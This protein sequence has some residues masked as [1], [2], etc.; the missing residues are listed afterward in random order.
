M[1]KFSFRSTWRKSKFIVGCAIVGVYFAPN[2][3]FCSPTLKVDK[4]GINSTVPPRNLQFPNNSNTIND[5]N[6]KKR[7]NDPVIDYINTAVPY[8]EKI[9][10]GG[11]MGMCTGIA[12][13]RIGKGIAVVIGVGFLAL[14]GLSY[15]GY[16]TIDYNKAR[17]DVIKMVDVDGDGK[18]TSNDFVVFWNEF[19][20]IMTHQ[21]PGYAGFA[22]G[23]FVGFCL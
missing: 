20:R 1:L 4:E 11:F 23:V 15:Y 18:L 22:S 16:V 2:T 14:Q 12:L 19:K 3:V 17:D 9:G 7:E 5:G 10:F 21:L 6:D 13:K 8:V